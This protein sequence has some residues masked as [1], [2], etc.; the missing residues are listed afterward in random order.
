MPEYQFGNFDKNGSFNVT[1]ISEQEAEEIGQ[2]VVGLGA[3]GI[4][5]ATIVG[6]ALIPS[7]PLFFLPYWEFQYL[8]LVYHWH[9]L[10]A[11]LAAIVS[12]GALLGLLWFDY[13]RVAYFTILSAIY[14][15]WVFDY[16]SHQ[17]DSI[18][19]WFW[20][21]IVFAACITGTYF[22]YAKGKDFKKSVLNKR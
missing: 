7:W 21:I 2:A 3:I 5:L 8:T 9:D 18:W 13:Y 15:F 4:A 1:K 14:A 17:S 11:G 12:F 22:A 16:V 19:G 6:I 20:C 10:F